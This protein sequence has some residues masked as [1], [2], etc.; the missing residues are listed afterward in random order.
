MATMSGLTRPHMKK[1][2][3]TARMRNV[4]AIGDMVGG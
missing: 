4:I 2:M 1:P 3:V